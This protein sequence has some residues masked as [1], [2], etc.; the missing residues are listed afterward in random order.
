MKFNQD[1]TSIDWTMNETDDL[2]QYGSNFINTFNQILDIHAPKTLVKPTQI[3][4]KHRAKPWINND[5]I[6][7]IKQKDKKHAK[8]IKEK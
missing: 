8:F 6:K 3:K 2:N 1:L 5:I 7:L 4:T